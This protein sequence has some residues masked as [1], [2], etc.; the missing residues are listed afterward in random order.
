MPKTVKEAENLGWRMVD[1]N[2]EPR[3]IALM[4]R[5]GTNGLKE[6]GLFRFQDEHIE[7]SPR[8]IR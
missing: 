7:L 4:E 5:D 8:A 2:W 1:P 3:K 6:M